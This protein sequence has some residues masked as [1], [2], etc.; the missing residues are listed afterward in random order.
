M[1]MMQKKD[2]YSR[3]DIVQLVNA[4]YAK[5]KTDP[6]ISHFFIK[7]VNV[8]WEQHLPVMY[9]FWENVLFHTS[10]YTGNPMV[11]HQHVHEKSKLKVSDFDQ[12]LKLFFETVDELYEGENAETIKQRAM[13]I[14]TVMQIKLLG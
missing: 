6:V 2:I 7:V 5:V 11:Q 14:A 13:S 8:N 1:K 12:W 9:S 3:S 4:F 10:N